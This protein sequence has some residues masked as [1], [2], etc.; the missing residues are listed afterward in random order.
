[1]GAT[2]AGLPHSRQQVDAMTTPVHKN[3]RNPTQWPDPVTDHQLGPELGQQLVARVEVS[4]T[5]LYAVAY[6]G[7]QR[8]V[9]ALV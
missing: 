3:K 9:I 6:P 4:K 5:Q 2:A 1:M 8:T 7:Q